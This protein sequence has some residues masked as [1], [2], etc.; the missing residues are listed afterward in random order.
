MQKSKA[1]QA[2]ITYF[3][4]LLSLPYQTGHLLHRALYK[5]GI[6]HAHQLPVPVIS[7]GNISFGGSGKT[8]FTIALANYLSKQGL[9]VGILTRGY[10]SAAAKSGRI[11]VSSPAEIAEHSPEEIGD[12]PYLMLTKLDSKCQLIVGKNRFRAAMHALTLA[13][14]DVFILDDG[15][16]HLALKRDLEIVLANIHETGFMRE[17][18]AALNRADFLIH[19]KVDARWLAENPNTNNFYYQ[20]KLLRAP[21]P[22]LPVAVVTAIADPHSFVEQLSSH[23]NG[24]AEHNPV[25][26]TVYS[27]SS[28]QLFSFPDHHY[29]SN[30]EVN[31]LKSLGMNLVCTL[32]DFVKIPK[33]DQDSFIPVDLELQV[34]PSDLF[35]RIAGKLK[36]GKS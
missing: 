14:Y 6:L 36:H 24:L 15:M 3:K 8:P 12:E 5:L 32:K 4:L 18:H 11:V 31:K 25:N 26:S 28:I 22:A 21:D 27:S 17:F 7:V 34:C 23:L 35:A 9:R 29:F 33:A 13:D 30:S 1:S 2:L 16:Q 20:L 19:T 10:N